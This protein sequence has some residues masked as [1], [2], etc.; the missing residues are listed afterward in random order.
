MCLLVGTTGVGKT[1]LLKRLQH[2]SN[3]GSFSEV[4]E[5]P[6]TIPTVG[7][8]LVNVNIG[9]KN[10]VT[11]RELGGCMGPIWH[12]YYKDCSVLMFMID[13]ANPCQ[14]ASSCIQL[15]TVLS[16]EQLQNVSVLL[17]LN[18]VDSPCAMNRNELDSLLRMRE[19]ISHAKQTITVLEISAR[20]GQGL[21]EL[22]K[23]LNENHQPESS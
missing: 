6:A 20:R 4:N 3:K 22:V 5:A 16:H 1:L 13:M 14:V 8:N 7:T 10:D 19:I 15:L 12:N 17:L 2:C 11:I 21:P 9:K 18:K 23:W